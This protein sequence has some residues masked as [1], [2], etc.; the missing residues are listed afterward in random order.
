MKRFL[1]LALVLLVPLVLAACGSLTQTSDATSLVPANANLIAQVQ[2]SKILEDADFQALYE[3]TP[4][5]SDDP[6]N[7]EELLAKAQKETGIDFSRFSTATLFGDVT[8]DD[9][10]FGVI[11]RGPINEELL[12]AALKVSADVVW[13]TTEYKGVRILSDESEGENPA[14]AVLDGDTTVLGTLPAIQAVIDVKQGDMAG[15]SGPVYDAFN[16]MG[17]PLVSLAVAIPPET[18]ANLEDSMGGAQGFGMVPAM[19]ALQD[20]SVMGF[21]VDKLGEDLKVEARVDFVNAESAN[22]M[23]DTLDG[24]LKLASAFAPDESVRSLLDK[25]E[26]TVDGS[27]ITVSFQA[28]LS[29]L[30]GVAQTMGENFGSQY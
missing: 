22:E 1:T 24:L 15:I 28:P 21:L 29:E 12:I 10:Y 20:I 11:V 13:S 18:V 14:I 26:L 27:N 2:L 16:D 8:Q 17:T 5:S 23:G 7:F 25:L 19:D 9:D 6:Q 4:K 30:E 3:Q